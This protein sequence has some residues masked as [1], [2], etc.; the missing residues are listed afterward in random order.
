MLR[1]NQGYSGTMMGPTG[2]FKDFTAIVTNFNTVSKQED[3][4]TERSPSFGHMP[5]PSTKLF[6]INNINMIEL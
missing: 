5:D 6:A 3:P 4:I 2:R 1:L